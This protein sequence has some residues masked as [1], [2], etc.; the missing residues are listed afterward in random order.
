MEESRGGRLRRNLDA[1]QGDL[2]FAQ[3]NKEQLQGVAQAAEQ[4]I[5]EQHARMAQVCLCV[6]LRGVIATGGA[7]A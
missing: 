2:A 1:L 4:F 6:G 5:A 3:A 7:V